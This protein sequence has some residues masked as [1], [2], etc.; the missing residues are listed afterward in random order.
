[1][2]EILD[3]GYDLLS[4]D[5]NGGS[6]SGDGKVK[7]RESDTADYLEKKLFSSNGSISIEYIPSQKKISITENNDYEAVISPACPFSIMNCNATYDLPNYNHG[8]GSINGYVMK[9]QLPSGNINSINLFGGSNSSL[10]KHLS[11]AFYGSDSD[12]IR[13]ATLFGKKSNAVSSSFLFDF[14]EDPIYIEKFKFYWVFVVVSAESDGGDKVNAMTTNITGAGIGT[15][16]Y[17]AGIGMVNN[18]FAALPDF[19]SSWNYVI[20]YSSAYTFPYIQCNI[21]K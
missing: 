4:I 21:S 8:V 11:I 7:C 15:W 1:M 12:D 10:N 5:E 6:G 18:P 13:T 17:L 19:T 9:I 3:S 14:S 16:Q 20:N 2:A